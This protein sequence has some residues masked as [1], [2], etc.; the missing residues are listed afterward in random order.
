MTERP[1][2]KFITLSGECRDLI[3][4]CQSGDPNDSC[5]A[6]AALNHKLL[7]TTVLAATTIFPNLQKGPTGVFALGRPGEPLQL[8]NGWFLRLLLTFKVE[9]SLSAG[10]AQKLKTLSSSIQYQRGPT[11]DSWVF[12]YEYSRLATNHYAPGHFHVRAV[13][14]EPVALSRNLEDVHFPTG[15]VTLESIIR[16]LIDDFGI[17]AAEPEEVWRPLLFETETAFL[18]IARQPQAARER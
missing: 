18:T 6:F 3:T 10:G 11:D 17:A 12:R 14:I 9:P 7:R 5:V 2:Q 16:L 1:N 4:Q 13:P 8:R 15:R